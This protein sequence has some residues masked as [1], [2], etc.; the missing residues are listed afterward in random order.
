MASSMMYAR[1]LR[2]KCGYCIEEISIKHKDGESIWG[3]IQRLANK[4]A[5][6]GWRL[7]RSGSPRCARC[8]LKKQNDGSIS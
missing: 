8:N 2:V 7:Y 4:V 3:M 1:K 5:S 6:G